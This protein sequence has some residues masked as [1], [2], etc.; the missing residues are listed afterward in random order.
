MK[1]QKI[2]VSTFGKNHLRQIQE[3]VFTKNRKGIESALMFIELAI[4]RGDSVSIDVVDGDD[5]ATLEHLKD[6][7]SL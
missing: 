3:Y 6:Y 2:S 5:P 4:L 1:I 7:V